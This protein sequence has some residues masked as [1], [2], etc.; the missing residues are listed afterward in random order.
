MHRYTA[1][2]AWS[3]DGA[4]FSDNRYS[5]GH[6]WSFDGGVVVPASASPSIVPA[7]WS[8]AEA[9]DPE[10]ALVAS[11]SSCHMLWF[12]S[13]A[14]KRGF[15]VDSYTDDAFGVMEKNA[16]GKLA[17]SRITLQPDVSFGGATQPTE[18]EIAFLHHDAHA[19]CF[20]ANSLK[21]E[22]VVEAE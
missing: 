10:E 21:C 8:V 5:R 12:L 16:E 17:F 13:L 7:P 6:E 3:R 22:I 4:T 11:A 19:E 1:R 20:I 15:V 2:T 14:A 9:V 18:D